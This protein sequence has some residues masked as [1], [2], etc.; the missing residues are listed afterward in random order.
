MSLKTM[1]V[2]PLNLPCLTYQLSPTPL[3]I[4]APMVTVMTMTTSYSICLFF[5]MSMM[6]ATPSL[7]CLIYPPQSTLTVKAVRT[8]MYPKPQM[9]IQQFFLFIIVM[10]MLMLIQLKPTHGNRSSQFVST[11]DESTN[12]TNKH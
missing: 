5:L 2:A 4:Q 3:Q 8:T 7:S 10:I 9:T 6:S 1:M 12:K 11:K